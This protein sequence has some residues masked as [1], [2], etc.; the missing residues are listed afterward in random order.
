MSALP[1]KA[2]I[3]TQPRDVRFV[4]KVA[5]RAPHQCALH[6][7]RQ[8]KL[9]ICRYSERR[10]PCGSSVA[11]SQA[12]VNQYKNSG[13]IKIGIMN[14]SDVITTGLKEDFQCSRRVAHRRGMR[15]KLHYLMQK[16]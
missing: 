7:M 5:L 15:A 4:P 2:D 12:G 6:T 16:K 14:E 13:A 10:R 8:N 9:D 11:M 3:E 1:P